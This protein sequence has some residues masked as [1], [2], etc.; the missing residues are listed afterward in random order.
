MTKVRVD[1]PGEERENSLNE[2]LEEEANGERHT[3]RN[4]SVG[5]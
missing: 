2:I 1:I 4:E 5:P 3:G